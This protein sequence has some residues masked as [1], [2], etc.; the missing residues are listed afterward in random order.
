MSGGHV[1]R[2]DWMALFSANRRDANWMRLQDRVMAH[3]NGCAGCRD[4]YEKGMALQAAARA[5]AG[6]DLARR[7]SHPATAR[8]RSQ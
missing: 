8:S 6:A 3:V 7:T 1:S 5:A 2:Q 4:L